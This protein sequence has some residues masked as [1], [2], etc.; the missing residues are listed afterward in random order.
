MDGYEDDNPMIF[1][2]YDASENAEIEF[3]LPPTIA[4]KEDDRI[5]P[6]HSGFGYGLYAVRTF[7]DGISSVN[8]LPQEY[9]ICQNYPNPFN[10][11]TVIPL[12]LP[13]RSQVKIELFNVAGRNLGTIYEGI[14]E[15]GW[16]KVHY[17]AAHLASGL[18][19]YKVIVEG[20]EQGGNFV[21]TGKMLLL[22]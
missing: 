19:F 16:P 17:N 22:K 10:A 3:V 1:I 13:Q 8:Q 6:T 4:S 2:W 7:M 9:K 18:Y 12:E 5:A 15:A 11:Q 14:K 20:L 21:D